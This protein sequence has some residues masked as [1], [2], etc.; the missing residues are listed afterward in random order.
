VNPKS[1]VIGLAVGYALHYAITT[2]SANR[3]VT[4]AAV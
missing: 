1:F 3:G 4:A 2:A